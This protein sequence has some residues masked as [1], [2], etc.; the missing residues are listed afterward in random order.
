MESTDC[1]PVCLQMVC[2]FYG[3]SVSQQ[4]I[5]DGMSISRIGVTIRDIKDRASDLGFDTVVA[6]AIKSCIKV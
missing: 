2:A 5:K 4:Y 1:G 3:K 6:K